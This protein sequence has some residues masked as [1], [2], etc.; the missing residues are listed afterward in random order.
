M[1]SFGKSKADLISWA[2]FDCVTANPYY[3]PTLFST[4]EHYATG[5]SVP[6]P[7]HSA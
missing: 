6:P 1:L 2:I 4:H 5:R 7:L 3:D